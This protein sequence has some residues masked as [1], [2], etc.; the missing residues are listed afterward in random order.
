[1]GA[2]AGE[3]IRGPGDFAQ[4]GD[5][6]R[7][8]LSVRRLVTEEDPRWDEFVAG[9][10][11]GHYLQ[12][13]LWAR[14]QAL[15]GWE[16]ERIRVERDDRVVGGAQVLVRKAAPAVR[17]G[18]VARGPLTTDDS[19][20]VIESLLDGFHGIVQERRLTGLI[21]Q[22]PVAQTSL[23]R[24]LRDR[25]YRR[26][27][28]G[29]TLDATTEIDLHRTEEEW[30]SAMTKS[31]RRSLRRALDSRWL[32]RSGGADD[33]GRFYRLHLAS[34][35]RQG[36]RPHTERYFDRL[37]SV[38]GPR[39]NARL[40]LCERDGE[41]VAG[42]LLI[43]FGQRAVAKYGGWTGALPK[44][45]PNHVMDWTAMQRSK[46]EGF[47]WYELEGIGRREA[48]LAKEGRRNEIPPGVATYK[49]DYG[50]DIVLFPPRRVLAPNR[51]V[52][53]ALCDV[54]PAIDRRIDV[55][56][57]RDRLRT[58]QRERRRAGRTAADPGED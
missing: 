43:T 14:L 30:L 33:L 56:H 17:F 57:L 37:W 20:E 16:A 41:T 32:V 26:S 22:P 35:R 2:R 47:R 8:G 13:T 52:R 19:P 12:S 34:S 11:S 50:G 46:A 25:T 6:Q 1:M 42:Q 15:G 39:G 44:L 7:S 4:G 23:E 10:A 9:H 40:M 21:V 5:E 36:F 3:T 18:L 49:L 53:W 28:I 55:R 31:H 58:R 24:A 51:M 48:Q 27:P 38:F 29:V 54:L 45:G